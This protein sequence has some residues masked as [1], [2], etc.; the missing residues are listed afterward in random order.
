M[1]NAYKR[2]VHVG[3]YE[4]IEEI[5]RGGMGVVYRARHLSMQ[6]DVAVKVMLD[7]FLQDEDVWSRFER[8][9]VAQGKLRHPNIAQA[10]DAGRDAKGQPYLVL[11]LLDGQ[12]LQ[13]ALRER[14]P[15]DPDD[16]ARIV[17]VLARAIHYAHSQGVLHRDL[18]PENVILRSDGEPVLT[19]FGLATPSNGKNRLTATGEVLGT[20]GY[21]SPEQV[22]GG[23]PPGP[24]TDVYGLGGILFALLT[25][26]APFVGGN[27]I[28]LFD[29]VLR[30]EPCDPRDL[31]PGL[32][33]EL[34]LISL[35]ALRRD[36]SARYPSAGAMADAL[37]AARSPATKSG[38]STP[39]L[40]ALV[41]AVLV[42]LGVVA[43]LLLREG[44][45]REDPVESAPVESAP[46]E[47]APVEPGAPS[48]TPRAALS[49]EQT[50]ELQPGPLRGVDTFVRSDG[51]RGNDNHGAFNHIL[52]GQRLWRGGTYSSRGFLRF[53]LSRLPSDAALI[54]ARL[55]LWC[56]R[57]DVF[58]GT[59]PE[60]MAIQVHAVVETKDASGFGRAQ[61]PWVEGS[62][63][64]DQLADGMVWN[65]H[66]I[67]SSPFRTIQRPEFTQPNVESVA[68]LQTLV[69]PSRIGW[70]QLEIGP[71]VERWRSGQLP[72]NGL[73]LSP[74]AGSTYSCAL[75]LLSSDSAQAARR[76]RLTI[77]YRGSPPSP[78]PDELQE[79]ALAEGEALEEFRRRITE[80]RPADQP[81]N[82]RRS[83]ELAWAGEC[84]RRA[85]H[86]G[87]AWLALANVLLDLGAPE[88]AFRA[89][90]FCPAA[91][92]PCTELAVY[93]QMVA[94]AKRARTG[95]L[96]VR[97][98]GQ[99]SARLESGK[100]DAKEEEALRSLLKELE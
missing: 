36:P 85:P 97:A 78:A 18:K 8:E 10:F 60:S 96:P 57:S 38:E 90:D 67:D 44:P 81:L 80:P 63:M 77:R 72:N 94:A 70:V 45:R 46:V 88:H 92:S 62:G 9:V 55:D 51:L 54:S 87:K 28:S 13:R 3:A 40:I 56:L 68:I 69:D 11:E 5:G 50:L 48:E 7:P 47:S 43:G 37:D 59:R 95:N 31:R 91:A 73:R 66:V 14:G 24:A 100:L 99:I 15:F 83:Q 16:A 29:K 19:D 84:A 76:P 65:G 35:R 74:A 21:M 22:D 1:P 41:L 61:T 52:V 82:E 6:R 2:L 98:R 58:S 42:L 20:P 86:S 25:G 93:R 34:S 26:R 33:P 32:P 27:A 53:D 30:E 89:L 75:F 4:V 23:H 71:L 12:S 49:Q 17:A 39:V 64:Y 79:L